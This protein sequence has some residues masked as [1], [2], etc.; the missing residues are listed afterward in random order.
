MIRAKICVRC[1]RASVVV[2]TQR[3]CSAVSTSRPRGNLVDGSPRALRTEAVGVSHVGLGPAPI[4]ALD[5]E[6]LRFEEKCCGKLDQRFFQVLD[7][8]LRLLAH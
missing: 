1:S 5:L 7:Y 2:R 4:C 3:S 8:I 6:K